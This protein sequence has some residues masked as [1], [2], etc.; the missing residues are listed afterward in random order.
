MDEIK[1]LVLKHEREISQLT[2][3][4]QVLV[5]QTEKTTET[6]TALKDAITEIKVSIEEQRKEL[7][8]AIEIRDKV[9]SINQNLLVEK[10][11][12]KQTNQKI[13]EKIENLEKEIEELKNRMEEISENTT[14]ARWLDGGF[15]TLS[16]KTAVLILMALGLMILGAFLGVDL[17]HFIRRN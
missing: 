16:K 17:H 3:I 7:K 12:Q 14:F 4:Q 8:I 10:N 1:E 9:D 13:F 11:N 2:A 6:L 15:K 5:Q